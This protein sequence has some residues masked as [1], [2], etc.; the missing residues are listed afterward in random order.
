MSKFYQKKYISK[1]TG[2]EID[3]A[4]AKAA[5]AFENPMTSAGD[6]IVGGED[7]AAERLAKG[8]DGKVLKMVSGSPAWADDSAGMTNPMTA[9]GDLI[10]GGADGAASRLGKGTDG[11]VLSMVSGAPAWAAA[12]GGA[13]HLY[14]H[15]VSC[16]TYND[17]YAT[18]FRFAFSLINT[19]SAALTVDSLK[20]ALQNSSILLTN[21]TGY[22]SSYGYG[23]SISSSSTTKFKYH[24]FYA[25]GGNANTGW[26]ELEYSKLIIDEDDMRTIF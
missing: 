15:K 6:I 11:Q 19:N 16:S 2:K 25:S 7:G 23:K 26:I 17:S 10:V 9:A 3:E 13:E 1:Y 21:G 4:V 18:T 12:S 24:Y 14:E 8:T 22:A 5:D 20:T